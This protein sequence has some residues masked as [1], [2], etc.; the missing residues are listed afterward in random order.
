MSVAA[1][2]LFASCK[3]EYNYAGQFLRHSSRGSL[4][5]SLTVYVCLPQ[6]VIHT[7]SSLNNIAGFMFLSEHEQ[8]SVI[9]SKT[10]I[11]NRLDDSIFLAQFGQMFLFTLSRTGL[12]IVTVDSPS[13]LPAANDSVLVVNFV[14]M[15]AEE[16]L[17]PTRSDFRTQRGSYYAYDYDLRQFNTHV[18]M[19]FAADTAADVYYKSDGVAEEFH[20]TVTSLR[21]SKA[22]MRT[23]FDRIDINDAYRLAR[24]MGHLCATLYVERL[25]G[26][27][28]YRR[29]GTRDYY[30]LYD[31][32][33]NAIEEILP[34]GEGI[35]MSFEKL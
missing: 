17:Q 31:A 12:P 25:I 13:R 26:D 19:Q 32:Q 15:E 23:Q 34:Y 10:V 18:W 2:L 27:Y 5:P 6:Q 29:S 11:L 28:A 33:Y 21:D 1:V 7:N 20:G 30:Y 8:D 35:R 4:K 24:R 22:T 9:A 14:Q 16:V 3:S